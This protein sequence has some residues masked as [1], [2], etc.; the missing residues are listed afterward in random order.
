MLKNLENPITLAVDIY[1]NL[2][3][4]G[5]DITG[6]IDASI[7]DYNNQSYAAFG[8]ELGEAVAEATLGKEEITLRDS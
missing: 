3:I 2:K 1:K 5:K 7:V 4:N 6:H 8:K